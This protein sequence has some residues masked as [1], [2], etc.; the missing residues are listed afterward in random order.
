LG[1]LF[2]K[3]SNTGFGQ[4]ALHE[5]SVFAFFRFLYK[6]KNSAEPVGK[7]KSSAAF[8]GAFPLFHRLTFHGFLPTN[9]SEEPNNLCAVPFNPDTLEITGKEVQIVENIFHVEAIYKY[10]ISDSGT[11]AYIPN[12]AYA[13]ELQNSFV[14]VNREGKEEPLSIPPN[15]YTI[16]NIS[17]DGTKAAMASVGSNLNM[18]ILIWDFGGETLK[19]LTFNQALDG[20]PLWTPDG[21]QIVFRSSRQG[22]HDGIYRKRA[23]GTGGIEQLVL[24]RDRG[25]FPSSWS[26]DGNTLILVETS[27]NSLDIGILPMK[28]NHE[29]RPLLQESCE[30]TDPQISPDGRWIAYSSNKSGQSEVY[31]RPF[32]DVEKG[33]WKIS[34]SGGKGT[35]WSRDGKEL[36]YRNGDSTMA[37]PVETRGSEFKYGTPKL[38]F[39]GTY[40]DFWDVHPDGNRFLML[41]PAK[42]INADAGESIPHKIIIVLN[43]FE[44]LKERVRVP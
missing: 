27:R 10:A 5:S 40:G 1:L 3:Q 36:F 2:A 25:L 22:G 34:K 39:R 16:F 32:P 18:D 28:G 29:I 31:V 38:L 9:S 17:P 21:Q 26:G 41:K 24:D 42:I 4:D 15:G 14:W 13:N 20:C 19:Q 7:W 11:L 6:R 23:D 30:E 44:E 12:T 43:W 37:V 35:R 8:C 33:L